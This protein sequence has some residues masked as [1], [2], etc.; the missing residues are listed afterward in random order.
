MVQPATLQ[1]PEP[2]PSPQ[3]ARAYN[4]FI[5]NHKR[6]KRMLGFTYEHYGTSIATL[7]TPTV[8]QSRPVSINKQQSV[9]CDHKDLECANNRYL[10]T[11]D[12][13]PQEVS[14]I[15]ISHS[16]YFPKLFFLLSTKVLELE[17]SLKIIS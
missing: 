2:I 8:Y 16:F 15:E 5:N 1:Q 4:C 11:R 12:Q 17:R 7:S 14:I 3:E 10:K 13:C 9:I 6:S